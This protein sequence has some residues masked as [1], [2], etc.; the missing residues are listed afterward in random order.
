M[1]V[2]KTIEVTAESPESFDA[3]IAEGIMRASKTVD[4]VQSA[5]VKSQSIELKNN[6]PSLYRVALKVT[7]ILKG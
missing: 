6:R 7:F 2:A 5:W 3:A 1:S 4:G